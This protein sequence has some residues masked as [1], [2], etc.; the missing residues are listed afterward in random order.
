MTTNHKE[1]EFEHSIVQHIVDHGGYREGAPADFDPQTALLPGTV[2]QFIKGTQPKAWKRLEAIHLEKT[3]ENI[4]KRICQVCDRQGLLHVLRK[5]ITDHG[6]HLDLMYSAP[7]TSLNPD[8][9]ALY[10]ANILTV[11]RQAHHSVKHPNDAV[12][13]AFFVNGLP[14]ATAELK[15]EFTGQS[16]RNAIKQYKNDREPG[17]P[18]FR[19]KAR[20]LVHFAVD[21][22][23][24]WM[25]TRINK[26]NTVFLPFNRGH[27]NAAGNPPNPDGYRTS[28]L[29][30]YVLS[31]DSWI[32]ILSRFLHL[33]VK[34]ENGKIVSEK[35]IF[36][37]YH[38]LDV[39]RKITSHVLQHGVG[40]NYLVQHSAGSGKS[41]SIAW[42]AYWLSS[43][44]DSN[45][46][47][48]FD[49]VVVVTD[50]RIL[51]K[52]LQDTIYQFEHKAGVVEPIDKHSSQLAA[53][54]ES[55]VKVIIT[56]L[57]KFP[58]VTEKIG[59]LPD[60]RYAVIVD[61]AHSSQTGESAKEMKSILSTSLDQAEQEALHEEETIPDY[62]DELIKSMKAR[63]KQNNLSFFA[64]TATPKFKTLEMFGTRDS[65]GKPHPFHLYSMRQAIEERFILDVLKNYTTYKTYFRVARRI[66]EDP[67]FDKKKAV[68]A[69]MKYI[70]Q[71]PHN[72]EQKT[73][74]MVEHFYHNTRKLLN[75][76]AKAMVVTASRLH[77]VQYYHAFKK[78]ITQQGYGDQLKI[79]VAFS[80]KV[81]DSGQEVTE[82][83]LNGFSDN[84]IPEQFNGEYNILI[85]AYKFQT[86]FDQPLLHT[87]YVDQRLKGVKAV[88]TLSRLNRVY[89]GKGDP[90]VLDFANEAED[91]KAAFEPYYVTTT[92]DEPTD[93]NRLYDLQI[94]IDAFQVYLP[95]E[96]E[97]FAKVFFSGK[98]KQTKKDQGMLHSYV[99][100]AVDR[101]R[102]L[103]EDRQGEFRSILSAFLNLYRYAAIIMPFA[104]PELEK[105]FVYGGFLYKKL[106]RPG[107]SEPVYIDDD[108]A[109]E[110]YR[111]MKI[112]DSMSLYLGGDGKE[113]TSDITDGGGSLPDEKINLSELITNINEL[114]GDI[115][116]REGDKLFFDQIADDLSVKDTVRA[117]AENNTRNNFKY[118]V[119]DAMMDA[120]VDRMSKNERM[121][122][123]FV[124]NEKFRNYIIDHVIIPS[125]Y[126]KMGIEG[127]GG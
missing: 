75:N 17:D 82:Y 2:I 67:Q 21:T 97:N 64:F 59:A 78:H 96:I 68:T 24:V 7:Q 61:E 1:Q 94:E 5:G 122:K 107:R 12:D 36:P 37:R 22:D 116:F 52:Q 28:Y 98:E 53:A 74:V 46:N 86:G 30:E 84:E 70:S 63:G 3:E 85:V 119:S 112:Q 35:L 90:F 117:Q 16:Y 114:F 113:L 115:D 109:L 87:M 15:T 14:V 69:L 8:A 77:A 93:P 81:I 76:R 101:Y 66:E 11:I 31:M 13:L 56:T 47:L 34:K 65:E 49:S 33:E 58:F 106:P 54:L 73:Q 9:V 60:R 95:T 48:I 102:N 40:E 43:L 27:D 32:D 99:D 121:A 55:G 100:P 23:E 39:V 41:N 123:Q 88:Q 18:I 45:D 120:V 108:V 57:Q 20:A 26:G 42:L 10:N 79:L 92:I 80:G 72:I 127:R 89:P 38:Q 125:I 71:H 19:F 126:Q 91:I 6:V 50:R 104:D 124:D 111:L 83:S 62:E 51:D 103:E 118:G 110:Y 44:H 25:T 105:L 4:I 29:W